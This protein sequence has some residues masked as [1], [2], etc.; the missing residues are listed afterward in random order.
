VARAGGGMEEEDAGGSGGFRHGAPH[1]ARGH[2]TVACWSRPRAVSG[3]QSSRGPGVRQ[4][5]DA[6][7]RFALRA[8][9]RW[10]CGRGR[11]RRA[12]P[13]DGRAPLGIDPAT[14]PG[15]FGRAAHGCG[16]SWPRATDR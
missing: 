11:G 2:G 4:A 8:S 1:R 9:A 3:R 5:A 6:S 12:A 14:L 13:R 16:G 7:L 15:V 10:S